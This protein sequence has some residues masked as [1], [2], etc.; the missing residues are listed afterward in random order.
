MKKLLLILFSL[1]IL[2]FSVNAPDVYYCSDDDVTG[3]DVRNNYKN[4]LF[5]PD[6][7]KI[8]IDFENENVISEKLY[9]KNSQDRKK[10]IFEDLVTNVLYCINDVGT[11][12]SINKSNLQ[13][14]RSVILATTPQTSDIFIAYGKCE[15]F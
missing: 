8:L 3:F 10:C 14:R 7:F 11:A 6:K 5:N 2:P 13:F 9:F 15:K 1:L 4:V 12:F